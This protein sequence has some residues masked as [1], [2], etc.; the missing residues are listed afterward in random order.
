MTYAVQKQN[1]SLYFKPKRGMDYGHNIFLQ[2]CTFA[3]KK[4]AK[5]VEW[6][7]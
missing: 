3:C 4:P 5:Q 1:S 7:T 2:V 6:K